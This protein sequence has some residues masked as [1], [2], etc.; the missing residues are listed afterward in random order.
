M[1]IKYYT[2]Q[3]PP[4]LM[5]E[6]KSKLP[7]ETRQSDFVPLPTLLERFLAS[8]AKYTEYMSAQSLSAEDREAL[9]EGVDVDDLDDDIAV[10]K[11]YAD[12]VLNQVISNQ[13]KKEEKPTQTK[14]EPEQ[15]QKDELSAEEAK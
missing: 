2:H 5:A 9:F 11:A 14:S 7:D 10:Q 4:P 13:D 3:N 12:E 15:A 1:K 6:P 8:G